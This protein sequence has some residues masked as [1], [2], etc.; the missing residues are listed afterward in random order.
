MTVR[1]VFLAIFLVFV[2]ISCQNQ[3]SAPAKMTG[4]AGSMQDSIIVRIWPEQ[5]DS[6]RKIDPNIPMID[7]RTELEFRTSHIFRAMS[8]DVNAPNFE[9]RIQKLDLET[10]VIVYDA[11]SFFSL[12]AAEK[13]RQ[14]GFKRVYELMGGIGRWGLS[15]KTL[16]SGES[17]I[18]SST[19]LK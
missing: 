17:K 6:L 18:D 11:N 9:Y 10:P 15:G 8:C 3:N 7:V 13:M 19:I 5:V 2:L 4:L 14:L 16:V 1:T 12:Q